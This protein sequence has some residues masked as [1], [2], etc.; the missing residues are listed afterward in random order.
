MYTNETLLTDGYFAHPSVFMETVSWM[1][2]LLL[3]LMLLLLLHFLR[4]PY[5][6]LAGWLAGCVHVCL[7]ACLA[8]GSA[9]PVK[10]PAGWLAGW[11]ACLPSLCCCLLSLCPLS[12][13]VRVVCVLGEGYCRLSPSRRV[14]ICLMCLPF[15]LPERARAR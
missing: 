14:H 2:L 15:Y 5:G 1:K 10:G 6:W 9:R 13:S 12:F 4:T 3:L 8:G 11:L 7:P